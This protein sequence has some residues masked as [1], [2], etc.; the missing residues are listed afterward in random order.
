MWVAAPANNR[1]RAYDLA[2][3]AR[4]R[5]HEI[6]LVP[7]HGSKKLE[8]GGIWSDGHYRYVGDRSSGEI[9]IYCLTD[10]N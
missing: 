6:V 9:Q 10:C 4:K 7:N 3:G 5:S 8:A 2:T 1:I